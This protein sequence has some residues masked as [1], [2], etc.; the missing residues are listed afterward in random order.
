LVLRSPSPRPSPPGR[1]GI[2]SSVWAKS[3]RLG[4]WVQCAN[5]PGKSHRKPVV[6]RAA[7]V[8]TRISHVWFGDRM[9]ILTPLPGPLLVWRGE[10]VHSPLLVI[11]NRWLQY[12]RLLRLLGYQLIKRHQKL[13]RFHGR[14][15]VG[16]GAGFNRRGAVGPFFFSLLGGQREAVFAQ[17]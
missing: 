15:R 7:S 11:Y 5:S 4:S 9:V 13:F 8:G 17:K 1:G 10:G 3:W 2:G 6:S 16:A 12:I 14:R